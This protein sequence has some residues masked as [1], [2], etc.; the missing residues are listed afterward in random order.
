MQIKQ[1]L[2]SI[3]GCRTINTYAAYEEAQWEQD[4]KRVEGLGF[5]IHAAGI[6]VAGDFILGYYLAYGV[7]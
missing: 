6:K 7:R 1:E 5:R 3:F 4:V 2:S